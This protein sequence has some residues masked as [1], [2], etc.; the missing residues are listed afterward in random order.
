MTIR[1]VAGQTKS[2]RCNVGPASEPHVTVLDHVLELQAS[3]LCQ[4]SK[5]ELRNKNARYCCQVR[6]S[7]NRD[8]SGGQKMEL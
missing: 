3:E 5:L 6:N 2:L 8:I 1:L 4:Q 7:L